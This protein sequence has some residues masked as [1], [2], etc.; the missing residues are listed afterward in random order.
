MNAIPESLETPAVEQLL[1][2]VDDLILD[3]CERACGGDGGAFQEALRYHLASGGK[4]TRA[5]LALESSLALFLETSD[6]VRLGA[7]VEA[8]HN[9]SLI[10]DDMQDG[11]EERRGHET[12]WLRFGRDTAIYVTDILLS[13]SYAVLAELRRSASVP[14]AIMMCHDSVART[15]RG[16]I[17]EAEKSAPTDYRAQ[18]ETARLKSGPLFSLAL[19]LPLFVCGSKSA[20]PSAR[21]AA[22]SFGLGYQIV[23]DLVD[24]D[25]D[26]LNQSSGNVV[27]ALENTGFGADSARQRAVELAHWYLHESAVTA[28]VL[29]NGS[30]RRLME[31]ASG[32]TVKLEAV[33][34]G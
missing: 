27:V 13:T 15:L 22:E 24:L 21:E 25:M 5:L 2:A 29:P 11:S 17:M 6:A 16:Q 18:L 3:L 32:L 23:D 30:G 20:I 19:E 12:V 28:E 10:Q 7:A 26:R 4:R 33:R 34:H 31:L 9:A 14:G 1:P 8:L